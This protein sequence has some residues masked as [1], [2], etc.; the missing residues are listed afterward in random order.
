MWLLTRG[1]TP[2]PAGFPT[3]RADRHDEAGFRAA[4]EAAAPEVVCDFIA[5]EPADLEP[6]FASLRGRLRQYVFVSSATVYRKPPPALPITEDTP[7][8]NPFWDYAQKKEACEA[9]LRERMASDDFPVTIVRPSHTYSRRWIPNP[10]SSAGY[11]IARRMEQG[12]PVFVP[13]NGENPWTLTHADD[14]AVGFC[15]LVG[16]E[17]A[18]GQAVHITSDEVL[19]WNQIYAEIA[20][21]AGV[22]DPPVLKIPTDFICQIAPEMTGPLKGDKAQPAIFDNSRIRRLVPEF[23]CR[24]PFREGVRESVRW[25]RAHPEWQPNPKVDDVCDRVCRTWLAQQAGA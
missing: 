13:D 4:L 6:V 14:F 25:L 1:Q 19:T 10:V 16:N 21:A 15:G 2:G 24:K 20:V 8:G 9:W 17:A 22:D 5:F 23:V 3:V 12:L 18:L 11:A 7:L